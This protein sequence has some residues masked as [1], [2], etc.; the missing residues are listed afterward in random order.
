MAFTKKT[1]RDYDLKGKRVLLRAEYDVPVDSRGRI[2]DDYR[3]VKSLPTIKFLIEQDCKIII[4][5]H[6]GR[7]GGEANKALSLEPVAVRLGELLNQKVR[8]VGACTGPEVAKTAKELDKG[9]ILLLENLRFYPEEEA[10][11]SAFAK[12]LAGL[13]EVFVQDAF[14]V[15]HRKHASMVAVTQFLPSISGLL[16]EQEMQAI[17]S[18][19]ENPKRPLMAIIGGAKI[20]DK[21]D[22]LNR[23]IDIADF[24]VVGGAMAN[25][26][27][28]ADD[29]EVGASIVERSEL[30]LAQDIIARAEAKA[31]TGNFVFYMPVDGVVSKT[32]DGKSDI[33]VVG[34]GAH[35]AS[36]LAHYP[37]LPA[38]D[39]SIVGK[40]EKI[41]DIG[42][43]SAA[44]IAGGMQLAST[45]IWN[46]TMGVTETKAVNGP[47]G[48][49]SHGT[50]T[51]IEAMLGEFGH[52]PFTLVG[53]GDTVGYIQER[54][55][56]DCFDHVS[57]GGGASLELM[58]GRTLPGVEA[59]ISN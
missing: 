1:I 56:A 47:I 19:I 37:K 44:F 25:T 28:L 46:G 21:I 42:P 26:L 36:E 49:F 41:L 24:V 14:G 43:V 18:V 50:E 38:S 27:L 10:N 4:C 5:S 2:T 12:Q 31:K 29:L 40:E 34:W 59:L 20:S 8:F 54:Q 53:G 48:P 57:T 33:R 55:L 58:A 23:L 30:E 51:I 6:M 3:I 32:I 35:S 52:R 16:I 39:A 22:V 9:Q 7:P 17:T 15:A 13:G 11:D 45:V